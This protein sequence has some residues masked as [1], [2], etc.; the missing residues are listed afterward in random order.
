MD[1]SPLFVVVEAASV[2]LGLL[3][4][5]PIDISGELRRQL[6]WIPPAAL[7]IWRRIRYSQHLGTRVVLDDFGTGRDVVGSAQAIPGRRLDDRPAF[8]PRHAD[9]QDGIRR[10]N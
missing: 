9:G 4:I 2:G 6:Y 1:R 7:G 3:R 8:D 5:L 10:W